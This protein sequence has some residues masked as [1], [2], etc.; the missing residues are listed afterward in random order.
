MNRIESN[1]QRYCKCCPNLTLQLNIVF[2][3]SC[4]LTVR[5]FF[6][7]VKTRY[8]VLCLMKMMFHILVRNGLFIWVFY[9][10]L[11]IR[12]FDLYCIMW[13]HPTFILISLYVQ[14]ASSNG[15]N[16]NITQLFHIQ[17]ASRR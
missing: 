8:V 17:Q 16:L 6:V 10:L 4:I 3:Y 9:C 7:V 2:S 5:L 1:L 12:Y 11:I 14:L 15:H 13:S